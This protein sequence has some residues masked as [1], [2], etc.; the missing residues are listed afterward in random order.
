MATT[1]LTPIVDPFSVIY[2]GDTCIE[3]YIEY[4]KSFWDADQLWLGVGFLL[5]LLIGAG[6]AVAITKLCMKDL[7]K[8]RMQD[9]EMA[10]MRARGIPM[11]QKNKAI[12]D[13]EN[14]NG[15]TV[16][17]VEVEASS[18]ESDDD[19]KKKKKR[20]KSK[21][22]GKS[23]LKKK[24]KKDP[25]ADSTS[26]ED[27]HIEGSADSAGGLAEALLQSN[28]DA[29]NM[30]LVGLDLEAL[31]KLEGQLWQE[32]I[33]TYIQTLKIQLNALF[34]DGKITESYYKNFMTKIE[35]DL[36]LI[37]KIC[38]S[39]K[40]EKEKELL[41]KKKL[42][43]DKISSKEAEEIEI[44]LA[45][46]H[47]QY[48]QKLNDEFRKF[49]EKIQTELT[50]DSGL[51][52][53][54]INAIMAKLA[55]D[56]ARCEQVLGD[57]R[58]RQAA[59]LEERIAKRRHLAEL[60]NIN[61]QQNEAEVDVKLESQEDMVGD[62]IKD[63]KLMERQKD[64]IMEQYESDL[65]RIQETQ[66]QNILTQQQSL[67]EKLK[68]HREA[69]QKKLEQKHLKEQATLKESVDKM[70]NTDDFITAY[71]GLI[72]Q[73]RIEQDDLLGEL[74]HRE[75]EEIHRARKE[76]EQ[77]R[78][79][80]FEKADE[81]LGELLESKA[82]LTEKE[83]A[84]IMRRHQQHMEDYER[85]KKDEKKRMNALLQEKLA[86]RAQKQ[87]ENQA[88]HDAQQQ[89]IK[90]QQEV[91]IKKVLE[92]Q[93]ELTD[94]AKDKI[95]AEHETNMTALN[96]QLSMS[97]L[98]Q[99]KQLEQKLAARKAKL[100]DLK[101]KQKETKQQSK[102]MN[103][104][105]RDKIQKELEANIA[106][107]EQKM[108]DENENAKIAFR[109]RINEET[110][111]ALK[112]QEKQ[113]MILIGKLQI[114]AVRRSNII[115][116]QEKILRTLEDKMASKVAEGGVKGNKVD[117]LLEQHENQT[118]QLTE[119]LNTQKQRQEQILRERIEQKKLK[120]ERE[121]EVQL[122][123]EAR[124]DW[125]AQ[126]R[127]G[128]GV[129]TSILSQHLLDQRHKKAMGD[130]ETEM[131]Y[132]MQKHK[133]ELNR[134]LEH[135]LQAEL[136]AQKKTFLA[137]LATLGHLSKDDIN[138]V[139]N[140]AVT[141]TGADEDTAKLLAKELRVEMKKAKTSL[142]FENDEKYKGDRSRRPN[143]A[144]QQYDNEAFD[145]EE[146]DQVQRPKSGFRK[147][148]KGFMT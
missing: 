73:Q 119:H 37:A 59:L 49:D 68:K 143:S 53:K 4:R 91:S 16:V 9:Q 82:Q 57:E 92:T 140:S 12:Y 35:S 137:Q 127:R 87:E 56:K 40:D 6:L 74:D 85:N 122:E 67:A 106:E 44:A 101:Q 95:M 115:E 120:R 7:R 48:V 79:E 99:Q 76:E 142:G 81:K 147:K 51:S 78:Q 11:H 47:P 116:H 126:K 135:E 65:R 2:S 30:I 39:E 90:Q 86:A 31:M 107:E 102:E 144:K 60:T 3:Y 109:N 69:K 58:T 77:F 100:A 19:T 46:L 72:D 113:L 96:N 28:S 94:S 133:D 1:A 62:L 25:D 138:E 93:L 148:K 45:N 128:A 33:T 34:R 26:V 112:A 50:K 29:A 52:E 70:V 139:V 141:D 108:N 32:K 38:Q 64:E 114:G 5:G 98:R 83:A 22:R 132:E 15:K 13:F 8:K 75:A 104:K 20:P 27:N 54:E 145:E 111:N 18:E 17:E 97:K 130:L 84:S 88:M 55:R 14:D 103:D 110:E 43:G 129:A 89:E 36:N 80:Q 125:E 146:E 41:D 117:L 121:V 124:E 123:E 42:K 105:E 71:H 63:G 23:A 134:E 136:D 118:E 131:K 61:K 10:M 21:K 24:V 66:E